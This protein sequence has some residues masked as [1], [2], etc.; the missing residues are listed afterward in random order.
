MR[1]QPGARR[2]DW[3][4]RNT[5]RAQPCGDACNVSPMSRILDA[6]RRLSDAF[7]STSVDIPP[8]FIDALLLVSKE[9]PSQLLDEI[10]HASHPSLVRTLC[11]KFNAMPCATP[12]LLFPCHL[13]SKHL[14]GTTEKQAL[15]CN[16]FRF[17][18]KNIFYVY[19][20]AMVYA[21]HCSSQW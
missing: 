5:H 20:R 2:T 1:Q 3:W 4:G 7:T 6:I 13:L 17:F 16:G 8:E 21:D 14:H 11:H 15:H 18:L 9:E 10:F 19:L 12:L